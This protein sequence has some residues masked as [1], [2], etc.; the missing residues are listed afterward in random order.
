VSDVQ[1]YYAGNMVKGRSSAEERDFGA[2]ANKV[3]LYADY[4]ALQ[5]KLSAV[6]AGASLLE[7]ECAAVLEDLFRVELGTFHS[8]SQMTSQEQRLITRTT[9]QR[10]VD[11]LVAF[12]SHRAAYQSSEEKP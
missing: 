7:G 2:H 12:R 6:Q 1:V 8:G 4:A 9:R 3:V 11:A 10:L 5:A